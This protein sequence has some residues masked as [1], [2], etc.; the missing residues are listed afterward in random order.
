M[1]PS[2]RPRGPSEIEETRRA[3]DPVVRFLQGAFA[4]TPVALISLLVLVFAYSLTIPAQAPEKTF[5]LNK[6]LKPHVRNPD[7][8]ARSAPTLHGLLADIVDALDRSNVTYWLVPGLGLLPLHSQGEGKAEGKLSPWQEGVDI[9]VFQE[10]LMRVVLAQTELQSTG[11][12]QVESYF[13]LRLFSIYG[14][15]DDRYDF[16]SPFLDIVYFKEDSG[17]AVS[18]CCDCAPIAISACT[19]KTCGCLVCAMKLD[20]IFPLSSIV[21]KG[22]RRAVN[23]PRDKESLFLPRDMPGVHPA[24][25]NI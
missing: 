25:L 5:R 3:D 9:G 8:T 20:E 21:I 19:K 2:K 11:I 4:L 24:V 1:E 12:V 18:Y 23:S 10:D 14:R 6:P 15:E 13:G 17:H 22:V 7:L 16:R